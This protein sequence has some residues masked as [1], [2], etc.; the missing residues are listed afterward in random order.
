M[1]VMLIGEDGKKI[2]QVS[3]QEAER[4]AK[5]SGKD[6]VLVNPANKVYR[7]MDLG[8]RKY[9]RKQKIKSNRAQRRTHKIKEV[10]LSILTD[11]H[12]LNVKAK[13]IREFLKKGLKTKITLRFRG[14]QISFKDSGLQKI[15]SLIAPLVEEK[16]ATIDSAPKLDGRNMVV[17]LTP[18][19]E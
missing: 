5:Q 13:R 6:L 16:I 7:I 3:M 14:R 18:Y 9:D 8:K 4:R 10:K 17:F 1:S 12:D 2:G 15:N 19:K 11:E